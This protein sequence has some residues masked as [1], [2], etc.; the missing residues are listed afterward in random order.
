L[1][2]RLKV[3]QLATRATL[4]KASKSAIYSNIKR[5]VPKMLWTDLFYSSLRGTLAGVAATVPM[6][7]V[8]FILDRRHRGGDLQPLPPRQI[9]LEAAQL[10]GVRNQLDE[11]TRDIL[12]TA[13]HFGYG[14]AMGALFGA[15]CGNQA[16]A[17]VAK[18]V[19]FG[20]AVWAGSY[21]GWLAA[22]DSRAAAP[23]QSPER[24]AVMFAAHLVW[25]GTLGYLYGRWAGGRSNQVKSEFRSKEADHAE[26]GQ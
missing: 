1:E 10:V 11:P 9:T 24:N 4:N 12:T 19:A 16:R 20:V 22:F 26:N 17:P 3:P 25:G 13:N 14:A 23:H 8:M 5:K 6:S 18:G 2:K 15:F 7:A 21:C